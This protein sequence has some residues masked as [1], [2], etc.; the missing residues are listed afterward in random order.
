MAPFLVPDMKVTVTATHETPDGE[1]R[2]EFACA[3]G[4]GTALWVG[5]EPHP[6]DV[7]DAELIVE[8]DHEWGESL[9][10]CEPMVRIMR[11]P[12]DPETTIIR[13]MLE[14]SEESFCVLRLGSSLVVVNTLGGGP[15]FEAF[16][17]LRTRQLRLLAIPAMPEA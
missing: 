6:D 3:Y 13:A 8:G 16:A 14:D 11:C 2:V 5:E 4:R 10:P 7:V 15:G 9:H 1:L 12:E 17:E